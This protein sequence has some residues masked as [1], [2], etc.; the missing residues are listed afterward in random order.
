MSNWNLIISYLPFVDEEMER[1]SAKDYS[2]SCLRYLNIRIELYFGGD[3]S[4][5]SIFIIVFT[6]L[7]IW[8]RILESSQ[9]LCFLT[10]KVLV[11]V[12]M[13]KFQIPR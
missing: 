3:T 5:K 4:I 6:E 1:F 12:S 11:Q 7:S 2:M 10:F 8:S 13:M 9:E